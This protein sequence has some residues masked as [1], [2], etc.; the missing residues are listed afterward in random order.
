VS[1]QADHLD[2]DRLSDLIDGAGSD[3]DLAHIAHCEGCK[4]R[5]EAWRELS[6]AVSA[7]PR[8]SDE[9]REAAIQAAL[10]GA[11]AHGDQ[12][13]GTSAV[14]LALLR[15][16][17]RVR[18]ISQAAAA[19][20]A[21]A[22]IAGVSAALVSGGGGGTSHQARTAAPT[23]RPA[24]GASSGS[25]SSP[26]AAAPAAPVSPLP[27]LGN[28]NSA[29]ELVT[30]LKATNVSATSGAAAGASAAGS[31]S[32]APASA[33]KPSS[34]GQASCAPPP[35]Q[36]GS[37]DEEATLVWKGTPAVAFVYSSPKGHRA[38]VESDSSCKVLA[39]VPY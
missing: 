37:L 26:S 24:G 1:R 19:A 5:W 14:D 33:V 18:V 8:A 38:V 7:I 28:V 22:L 4:V 17:R 30:A 35:N 20:A 25:A 11:G 10:S 3:A 21:V 2:D 12:T 32:P 27:T 39:A 13:S 36:D 23:T 31:S 6:R 9:Q 16:R 34:S 29:A 15:K